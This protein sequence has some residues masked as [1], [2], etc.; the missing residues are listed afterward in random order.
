MIFQVGPRAHFVSNIDG[1][2][3]AEALK[4]CNPETTLFVIAS[5]TFTTQETI[6]NATTAK[7]W[8]LK[9]AGGDQSAVAKHF[10]A[11]STNAVKVKEFGIDEK[12]MFG[13]WD[14]VGGELVYFNLGMGSPWIW[15]PRVDVLPDK[16]P[17]G[18]PCVPLPGK[19]KVY[20]SSGI[21]YL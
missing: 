18:M 2:H 9:A 19:S 8:L 10:C 3:M 14:W 13:F 11:L 5:K 20:S 15:V 1:T 12:N 21:V 17:P 4:K 16:G 7:E 6:T